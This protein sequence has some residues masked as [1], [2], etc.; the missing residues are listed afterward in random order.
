MCRDLGPL[1]RDMLG[2]GLPCHWLQATGTLPGMRS[3]CCLYCGLWTSGLGGSVEVASAGRRAGYSLHRLPLLL[4]VGRAL[5][6]SWPERFIE[7]L[8]GEITGWRI[9]AAVL[10]NWLYLCWALPR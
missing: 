6:A 1:C 3:H 10:L 2:F 5:R 9:M 8:R 7:E 4:L